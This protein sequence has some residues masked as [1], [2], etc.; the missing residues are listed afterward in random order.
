MS[1]FQF[2]NYIEN[3]DVPIMVM[4][5]RNDYQVQ[6]DADYGL[7]QE[8]LGGREY[9]GLDHYFMPSS[10]KNFR[11]HRDIIGLRPPGT[12]VDKQVLCDIVDW[13]HAN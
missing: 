5:G 1:I 7:L 10:A 3:I 4:Q 8:L 2:E 6:A 11:E 12:R 9:D 13:V